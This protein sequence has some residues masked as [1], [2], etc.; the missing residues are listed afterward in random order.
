MIQ[1]KLTALFKRR[2]STRAILVLLIPLLVAVNLAACGRERAA[3]PAADATRDGNAATVA[4][5][6]A[7]STDSSQQ[8]SADPTQAPAPTESALLP[9]PADPS[10]LP[11]PDV[12]P[13]TLPHDM[14]EAT[15]AAQPQRIAVLG[16]TLLDLLLSLNVQPVG[17]AESGLFLTDLPGSMIAP[18]QVALLGPYMTEPV[19]NLGTH[20]FPSLEAVAAAEPDLILADA[21]A[22]RRLYPELSAIAPTLVFLSDGQ[23]E[24]KRTL[25]ILARALGKNAGANVILE[26]H[27]QR[28]EAARRRL[29]PIIDGQRWLLLINDDYTRDSKITVLAGS[30]RLVGVLTNI[31]FGIVIGEAEQTAQIEPEMLN[32]IAI[33]GVIALAAQKTTVED[34]AEAWATT[35]ALAE[36]QASRNRGVIILTA[37]YN[38]MNG[39]LSTEMLL[40]ELEEQL[41]P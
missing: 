2:R 13:M 1:E 8:L 33:D 29:A 20:Q 32:Q 6:A 15:L 5:P 34:A 7:T 26:R 38:R 22:H 9:A 35:P 4:E 36:F 17:Y 24:W 37:K 41:D 14:G 19:L 40:R 31:G 28:M 3:T 11:P 10:A 27:E 18:D 16:P 23:D 39:P 21:D 30:T 25:P 12:Y